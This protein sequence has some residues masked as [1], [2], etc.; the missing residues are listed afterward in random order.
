MNRRWRLGVLYGVV[1][2]LLV[3]MGGWWVY[4]LSQEGA[5][6]A[7]LRLQKLAND[8][9]HATF[10]LQTDPAL[11]ADP[12]GSLGGVF[13]HLVYRRNEAGVLVAEIDPEMVAEIRSEARR[14]RNMFIWEGLFFLLLLGAAAT[15]LMV[16]MRREREF[17]RARELFL[18]GAT[19][20]FKTPLASLRLYAQTLDREGL[21]EADRRRIRGRM[22][23]DLK[24]LESLVNQVLAMS[25]DDTFR[26]EPRHRID[27]AAEA[28]AVLADLHGFFASHDARVE[29]DLPEGH[30]ILGQRLPLNLALRNLLQNAVKFSPRPAHVEVTLR[31][32][33]PWHR[34]AVR[35]RGP[36]IPRRLHGKV[37]ECFYT[38][39]D[40]RPGAG[41]GLYLVR[42]NVERLGGHVEL[43]SGENQGATFT[44]VLPVYEGEGP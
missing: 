4:F 37:F 34:L 43:Q 12:E 35:D 29:S 28:R 19:H 21:A 23:E 17:K 9:L 5:A 30:A 16:A 27:L 39:S 1:V 36:G 33:G 15:I 40:R 41:L 42:R 14:R 7:D 18:A 11:R 10:L 24:T 44:L 22:I 20:E 32:D 26:E 25:A 3:V 38:G 31:R 6:Y 8:R 2:G 13:P